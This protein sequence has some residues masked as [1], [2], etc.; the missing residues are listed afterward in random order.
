MKKEKYN[1]AILGATGVVGREM[2]GILEERKFPVGELRLF[3]TEK[4]AGEEI[5]FQGKKIRVRLV[6]DHAFEGI[7]LVMGDTP[8]PVSKDLIP[9]AVKQGAIAIDCSSAFRMDPDVPLVVPEVNAHAIASHKGIIAG[10]N[11]S[12]IP[13]AV[14]VKPILEAFG[15]KRL[16]I[17]TYQSAS[18]AGK[19]GTDELAEQALA[20]FNQKE[21]TMKVFPY[22]LAFNVIPQID[23]FLPGGDTKEEAK[24]VEELKKMIEAPNM[25]VTV[26]AVRV[27]V[28]V[29]HSAA[30]NIETERKATAAE[31]RELL[32]AVPNVVIK[33]NPGQKD[34]P[35]PIDAAG[36]DEVFIGR[37]REDTSIPNGLNLWVAADNLRK[38]A[39]LNAIHIA[40]ILIQ[41]YL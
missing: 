36:K 14:A 28:F 25:G 19:G 22:R 26:T 27:P 32:R 5:E 31:V 1:V 33:D 8:T 13:V 30:V 20:L 11:C 38:G 21:P 2:I 9:K 4:S 12:A 35:L 40:E 34:Y 10:A 37:I 3:A 29:G 7:D 24:I 16:V 39:A 41:K 15:I 6:G 18:G 17:S 23:A